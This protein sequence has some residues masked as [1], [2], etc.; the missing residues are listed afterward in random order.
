MDI[1]E[2]MNTEVSIATKS[3]ESIR[4]TPAIVSVITEE[5]I[6]NMGARELI[7]VL[8]TV[9]GF[10]P[11]QV[12][13]GS[14]YLGIRGV[15]DIR[16]GG[17]LLVLLDG[18]PYNDIMYSSGLF[19]GYE[20]NLDAIK[21][22]EV[23]RGPGSA[24]YGTNAFSGVINIITKSGEDVNGI[25]FGAK[26]GSYNNY[27]GFVNAGGVK[28]DLK[29]F[30]SIGGLK[31]D[32]TDVMIDNGSGGESLYGISH[33]NIYS[34]IKMQ[35]KDIQFNGSLIKSKDG[36][37]PG[38]FATNSYVNKLVGAYNL[39]YTKKINERIN[40]STKLYGR[41]EKRI[42]DIELLKPNTT[43]ILAINPITGDTIRYKD[44]YTK[45]IYAYVQFNEY[46]Y[47]VDAE[48]NFNLFSNNYL[49]LGLQAEMKGIRN[50]T[51][52]ANYNLVTYAPLFDTVSMENYSRDN[53]SRYQP[54]WIDQGGHAYSNYAIYIQ[55]RYFPLKNL[56]ITLGGRLDIDSENGISFNPRIGLVYGVLKN[57]NLKL[58]YSR[59]Y[60]VPSTNQHYKF[61]GFDIGNNSLKEEVINTYEL[62]VSH[63]I[64]KMF[65]QLSVYYNKL[66][67]LIYQDR[68]I[69]D[70]NELFIK[71]YP[72][73]VND[74]S[75]NF[76]S[77][78][79]GESNTSYGLEYENKILFSKRIYTSINYSFSHS[80]DTKIVGA[81]K[82]KSD[83]PN[84]SA[85]RFN[86]GLNYYAA[87]NILFNINVRY[88]GELS[89]YMVSDNA[90][91][92]IPLSQLKFGDVLLLNSTIR[93]INLVP[94]FEISASAYNML[95]QTYYYQDNQNPLQPKQ[96]GLSFIL[97]ASYKF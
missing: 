46:K 25:E 61:V 73:Y 18:T 26:Y 51:V 84:V 64:D 31:T 90:G 12:R 22:I 3:S 79:N 88:Q 47:G 27:A 57:T 92:K 16:Q 14:K 50:A 23:I 55:D 54:G 7:D 37:V 67:N 5:E 94:G 36:G 66:E 13:L 44:I 10:E 43:A 78:Y 75:V 82:K 85:H 4:K 56:A 33:Q 30:L 53:M 11:G 15:T 45:G 97:R 19:Y 35:Y 96:N 59:A 58:L 8:N 29:S 20:F 40:F 38:I 80:V 77:Y 69:K 9:P 71:Y 72:E 83:H 74:T 21:R 65:N 68:L 95:N 87:K 41:N 49:L 24:L 86:V 62:A 52:D 93:I 28:N 63:Q 39:L 6:K 81:S 34:N 1:E 76:L 89:K 91:N 48:F 42:E 2:L 17:K 32:G 70:Q 60:S